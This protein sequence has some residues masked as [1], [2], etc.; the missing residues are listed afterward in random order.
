MITLVLP[1]LAGSSGMPVS[2]T[3]LCQE[4]GMGILRVMGDAGVVKG[5]AGAG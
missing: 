4:R 1:E 3:A 2:M 5:A